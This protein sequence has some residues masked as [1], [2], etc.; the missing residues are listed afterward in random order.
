M[1]SSPMAS[2]SCTFSGVRTRVGGIERMDFQRN[3]RLGT[4]V[5]I[6]V[7]RR[8]SVKVAFSTGAYTTIGGDFN[9][10]AVAYQYLWGAGL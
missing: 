3:S 8:Q 9:S 7:D 4:T 5:S 6:P 1:K 2:L 10:V